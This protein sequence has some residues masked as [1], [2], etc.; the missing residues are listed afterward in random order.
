MTVSGKPKTYALS[1][2]A[3]Q[4][5]LGAMALGTIA[6]VVG[7]ATDPGRA[8][9]NFLVGY[10]FWMSIAVGGVFFVS[11]QHITGSTWSIPVRRIPETFVAFIPVL[12]GLFVVLLFGMHHLYEW[13]HAEVVAHDALLQDKQ[14]YLNIPF[15]AA[16][17]LL[18]LGVTY[19]VGRYLL[20]NSLR[21]DDSGDP[22][23]T[24][25]NVRMAGV[26]LLL[27]A[28]LYTFASFDLLMSLA[29][30][31]FSTIFGVYCFAGLFFST[32]AM[33]VLWAVRLRKAGVL[34][35]YVT[36]EHLHGLGKFMFAFTVFW[37]YIAF[38]QFM[39]IWYAN[40]PEE[41]PYMLARTTGA[42][43]PVSIALMIGK[44]ALPFALIITQSQKRNENWLFGVACWFVVAQWLDIY[45]MVFPT[46]GDK[47][48]LGWMEL[49]VFA[50]FTG[51]FCLVVGRRLGT[52]P[53]VA[54]RDPY[55]EEGIRHHQ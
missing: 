43:L 27:F 12:A 23:L 28:W 47:P 42:W 18:L 37:A 24:T 26:F 4:Y 2:K 41:T 49:G 5:C 39:L 8:W 6:F 51:L 20:R 33:I 29:P 31:W 13:T 14:V 54:F 1:A 25:R 34:D 19:F 48:V 11:L 52:V 22:L 21:Q 53:V 45:W 38:S 3:Q 44:F 15:F 46:F 40:L 50:G 17:Q 36:T 16:R 30:H 9:A 10:F 35:G 32:V 7:L 55:I